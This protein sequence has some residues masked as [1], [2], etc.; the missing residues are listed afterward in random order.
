MGTH[1]PPNTKLAQLLEIAADQYHQL[2]FGMAESDSTAYW[3]DTAAA[4]NGYYINLNLG[5]SQRLLDI[6]QRQWPHKAMELIDAVVASAPSGLK[7][8]HRIEILFDPQLR[9]DPLKS[10]QQI[11]RRHCLLV[12]WPGTYDDR[13]LTYAEPAHP[14]YRRYSRK[15]LIVFPSA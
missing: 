3:K 9:L 1:A 12:V 8:L 4:L 13:Y 2:V 11:S 6:P 15:D 5:L 7:V 14:E 10:L